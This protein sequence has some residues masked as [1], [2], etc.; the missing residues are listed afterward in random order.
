[1]I[2]GVFQSIKKNGFSNFNLT[3]GHIKV[4]VETLVQNKQYSTYIIFVSMDRKV[5]NKTAISCNFWKKKT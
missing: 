5:K 2:K 4:E 3:F 1:M